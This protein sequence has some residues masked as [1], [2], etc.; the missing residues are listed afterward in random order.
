MRIETGK[1]RP[2]RY[3]RG[4]ETGLVGLIGPA[5]SGQVPLVPEGHRHVQH[6][7]DHRDRLRRP[8]ECRIIRID[9]HLGEHRGH[10]TTAPDALQPIADGLLQNKAHRAF[11]LRHGQIESWSDRRT[12]GVLRR[13]FGYCFEAQDGGFYNPIYRHNLIDGPF[14]AARPPFQLHAGAG[15][16]LRAEVVL[17]YI[18]PTDVRFGCAHGLESSRVSILDCYAAI[19]GVF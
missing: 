4:G 19:G 8:L 11:R 15:A 12:F 7:L 13:R 16:E 6:Y 10:L 3:K 2:G 14:R 17:G 1:P 18:L 9:F 5:R